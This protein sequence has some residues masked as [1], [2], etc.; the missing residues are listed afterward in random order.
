MMTVRRASLIAATAALLVYLPALRGGFAVDDEAIVRDNPAAQDVGAALRA[1]G[2]PYWPPPHDAGQWRPLT[3]L[4]FAADWQLSGGRTTW[5]HAG[6]LLWHAAVTGLLV[7][8]LAAY[9]SVPAALA[10]ALVFAVH[11]VHVEAVANLV[12]RAESMVAA[13]LMLALLAA[14]AAR[15]R[16]A[17]GR[18]T[19]PWELGVFGAVLL[20]LL[21]KEHAA[22]A[23]ALLAVDGLATAPAAGASARA[24]LPRR[25]WTALAVLIALWLAARRAVEGGLS[26]ASVAPTF[27][28]QD[29]AG[30]L[31]TMGP[32]AFDV[33]R[34]LVW[35]FALSPD[36]HPRV[37]DRLEQLTA[38]GAAGYVLLAALAAL[39]LLSWRRHRPAAAGLLVIGI[40][41]LPTAN[42][43]FAS[44]IVLAER[45]L[46]LSSVGLALLA[47]AGADALT[48]TVGR[49]ATVAVL[50][51]VAAAF[52]ART[53]TRIP[54]WWSTR[55]LVV[56]GVLTRPESY[57]VHQAAA[58][59]LMKTGQVG[60]AL[61]E[62]S[63]AAELYGLDP[64]L[65][66]EAGSAALAAGDPRLAARF[67]VQSLALDSNYTP[68]RQLLDQVRTAVGRGALR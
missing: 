19:W 38:L 36:Y 43:L 34:L 13:F 27:F 8:V 57:K 60:Q 51:I 12:G 54:V 47:A 37:V 20:G 4:S 11:P 5:L 10:G 48:A 68:T 24:R 32:V 31:A 18:R 28:D 16:A 65:L 17:G 62:Y 49:R 53:L 30:R 61:R 45:T 58:R 50:A 2:D 9:A 22:V 14:R 6:N 26:F 67:L 55:E 41:W 7:P 63:L 56:E 52:G 25:T 39:A 42:L 40:A 44:G 64:Y 3:I 21:A 35:P 33:V 29:A 23:I 15:R 46:Y 66:T 1:F 59:V